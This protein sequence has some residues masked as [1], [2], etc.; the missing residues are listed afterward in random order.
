MRIE[1]AQP[2]GSAADIVTKAESSASRIGAAHA[3]PSA[4]QPEY[5]DSRASSESPQPHR[6]ATIAW[7]DGGK[8]LVYQ[9]RDAASGDVI[10]QIPSDEMLRVSRNI[11]YLLEQEQARPRVDLK[12]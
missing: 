1:A 12:F 10:C 8:K 3:S 6:L 4:V 11:A 5:R 7:V 9:V 2:G